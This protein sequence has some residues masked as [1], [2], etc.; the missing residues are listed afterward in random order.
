MD[1]SALPEERSFELP[2]PNPV[3][4]AAHRRDFFRRVTLPLIIGLLVLGGIALA[5]ILIPVG[6]VETWSQI[7]SILLIAITL[8]GGLI[9]FGIL[10]G[11][12]YLVSYLL[13]ILPPYTRMA[14]DGIEKIQEYAEKGADIPVRPI[15][16]VQSFIAA[17]NA[18]F[19]RKPKTEN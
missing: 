7:S 8:I 5:F 1:E 18:L 19:N 6:D 10:G 4:K 17:I 11:L 14:Q 12:V 16:Q 9:V 15:I 3:T 2:E 13:G